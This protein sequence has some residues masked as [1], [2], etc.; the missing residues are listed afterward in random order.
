LEGA[1]GL[2]PDAFPLMDSPVAED[3]PELPELHPLLGK[4][5]S[6]SSRKTVFETSF[7]TTTPWTDH[8]VLDSTVFPGTGYVE[9]AARGFAAISGES[10]QA[11]IVKDMA[12]ERP[13]L[14]SYREEKKVKLALEQTAH[15]KGET[16]FSIAASDG[17][18]VYCR[19]RITT[20][21]K[22]QEQVQLDAEFPDRDSEVKIGVFYGELRSRGLEYGA[23]FANVRELWLGKPGS[24]EAFGRVMNTQMNHGNDPFNNAVVLDGC[25]Q[26]F[27]AALATLEEMNQPGAFVPATI[28]SI[29]FVGEL[30]A[31]VWSHVK[32]IPG[33]SGRGAV[34]TIRILSD[35]GKVLATFENLELRRTLSLTLGKRGADADR[36]S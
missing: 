5:V 16:K 35:E 2:P 21:N 12:F 10:S 17:S 6:R 25:L 11:V 3:L 24:G 18:V 36:Q 7:K 22:K 19:G 32:V 31:Q 29:S 15:G 13:L 27:G 9:I 8:R 14:L 28:Q 26:V 1:M 34:A 33:Q 30:P 4:V 20:S 23:R